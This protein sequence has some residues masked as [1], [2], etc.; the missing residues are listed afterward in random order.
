MY[1]A[2]RLPGGNTLVSCG[3]DNRV[4]EVDPKGKI[5]WDLRP[6]DVPEVGMTWTTS[7]EVL[8]NGHVLIGNFLNG[9]K[10]GGAHCFEVTREKKLVWQ[11]RDP[12]LVNA[13]CQVTLLD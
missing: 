12:K 4:V 9:K 6:Q 7:V 13:T 11:F 2:L 1:Q 5:V 3:T 8:R 10:E